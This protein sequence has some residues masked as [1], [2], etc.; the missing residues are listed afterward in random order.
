[1]ISLETAQKLK[2]AGLKWEPQILDYFRSHAFCTVP[3]IC[4]F[5]DET[6]LTR[7][8]NGQVGGDLLWL[9]RL[10]QLLAEIEGQGYWWEIN[11]R[12]VDGTVKKY[13]ITI[14]KKHRNGI[15]YGCITDSPTEAAAQALLWIY[16]QRRN[17]HEN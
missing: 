16:E 11:H 2:D 15:N 17:S 9:P 5:T 13:K 3:I 6:S 10:D 12:L 4:C 8:R 7:V 14:S 1:M